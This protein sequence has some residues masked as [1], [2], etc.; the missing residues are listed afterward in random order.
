M[1]QLQDALKREL[2]GSDVTGTMSGTQVAALLTHT[3]AWASTTSS[4]A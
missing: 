2:R 4:A 1:A 3:D